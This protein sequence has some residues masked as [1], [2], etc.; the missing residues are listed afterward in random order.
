MGGTSSR[1]WNWKCIGI[2]LHFSGTNHANHDG[3]LKKDH[4]SQKRAYNPI[5]KACLKGS[6]SINGRN[7]SNSQSPLLFGFL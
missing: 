5:A 6:F 2:G 1:D 3:N 7:F 4:Y